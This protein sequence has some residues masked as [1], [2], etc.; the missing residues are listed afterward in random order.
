MIEIEEMNGAECDEVLKRVGYGHLACARNN[1]PYVVPI[2]YAYD[3]PT[4]YIYTTEGKKAEI[5][6]V[7]PQICLQV[8]DVEDNENWKSVIVIGDAEQLLDEAERDTA[9]RLL[10][11]VNPSMTPAVS[12]RWMDSWVR[13][14]IEVIYRIMPRMITGRRTMDRSRTTGTLAPPDHEKRSTI[15]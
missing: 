6:R 11:A 13:E 15:Y 4:I 5:I 1:Q 10:A 9:M 8:E 2:H 7:N 12:I 14:N 3:K